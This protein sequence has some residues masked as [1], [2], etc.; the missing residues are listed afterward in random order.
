MLMPR[1][2]LRSLHQNLPLADMSIVR[3]ISKSNTWRLRTTRPVLRDSEESRYAA[4]VWRMVVFLVSPNSKHHCMPTTCFFWLPRGTSKATLQHLNRLVNVI[5]DTVPE[6][7]WW[8]VRAWSGLT[9][10]QADLRKDC[11]GGFNHDVSRYI[12]D[13]E[14][15]TA[16]LQ[17][18]KDKGSDSAQ[19]E[20]SGSGWTPATSCPF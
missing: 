5:T 18:A 14:D 19:R 16:H 2:D 4:Y 10:E 6:E 15:R 13:S 7:E 3:R 11:L 12:K 8:G 17:H 9:S 1:I 20:R